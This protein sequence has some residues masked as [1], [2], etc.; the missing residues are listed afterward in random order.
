M[1]FLKNLKCTSL[2]FVIFACTIHAQNL[3]SCVYNVMDY[4]A[5]ADGLTDS[6]SVSYQYQLTVLVL[7]SDPLWYIYWYITGIFKSMGGGMRGRWSTDIADTYGGV[8]C[9]AIEIQRTLQ[10]SY[11]SESKRQLVSIDKPRS[12]L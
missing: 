6:T 9:R 1:D 7:I 11:V 4:G 2:L 10:E 5:I 12:V 8:P 3:S